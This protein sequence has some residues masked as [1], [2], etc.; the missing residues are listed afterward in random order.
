[1]IIKSKDGHYF[2]LTKEE[3]VQFVCELMVHFQMDHKLKLS[4]HHDG[5]VKAAEMI[6]A[7]IAREGGNMGEELR[8]N[9]LKL[10]HELLSSY[11]ADIENGNLKKPE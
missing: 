7:Q 6:F 5:R 3:Y 1:M 8:K 4:F 9:Y 10:G 11:H 2:E